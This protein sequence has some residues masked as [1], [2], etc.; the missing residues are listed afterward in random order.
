MRAVREALAGLGYDMS[1]YH[2]ESFQAALQQAEAVP[3]D[4][5][6]DDKKE[7]EIE[8][9]LSGISTKCAETDTILIAGRAAGLMIPSGC[10]MGLCGTCK[11]R[12]IEGQVHMVHNGGITDEDIADNYILACCSRPIGFVK[13]EI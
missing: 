3:A 8:F 5:V 9:S 6:P 1:R 7:A 10:T 12:K 4:I 13:L 11:V 2:Q